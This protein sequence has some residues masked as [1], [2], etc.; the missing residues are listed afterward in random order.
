[1]PAFPEAAVER[2]AVSLTLTAAA[3][4]A[5]LGNQRVALSHPL[6]T[7]ASAL[8]ARRIGD[9]RIAGIPEAGREK[10]PPTG[11]NQDRAAPVGQRLP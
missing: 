10:L 4:M 6:N 1:L 9:A 2:P 8:L 3:A 11:D 5:V 7:G